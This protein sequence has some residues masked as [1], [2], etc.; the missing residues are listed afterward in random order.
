MPLIPLLFLGSSSAIELFIA[1]AEAAV[2][3]SLLKS[4]ATA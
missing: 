2:A 3:V 1:G 4:R